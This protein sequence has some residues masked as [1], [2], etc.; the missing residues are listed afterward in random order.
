MLQYLVWEYMEHKGFDVY[1]EVPVGKNRIDLVCIKDDLVVGLEVKRK[2][3]IEAADISQVKR[4]VRSGFFSDLALIIQYKGSNT[5]DMSGMGASIIFR[6]DFEDLEYEPAFF[7]VPIRELDMPPF[8]ELDPSIP[9]FLRNIQVS[10]DSVAIFPTHLFNFEFENLIEPKKGLKLIRDNEI[11]VE[12]HLWKEFRR[13]GACV[14]PQVNITGVGSRT[15]VNK[16][17]KM[18]IDLLVIDEEGAAAIEVKDN[19][20]IR[21][22]QI[23]FYNSLKENGRLDE[24]LFIVPRKRVKQAHDKLLKHGAPDIPVIAYEEILGRSVTDDNQKSLNEF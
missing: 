17:D 18:E 9:S 10:E 1:G 19:G 21:E 11:T 3:D 16:G 23:K 8:Y 5:N 12:Y 7:Y 22:E 24:V 15:Q 2:E 14:L 4:Y 20:E 6:Q 13:E